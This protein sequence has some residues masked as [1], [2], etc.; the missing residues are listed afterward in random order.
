[1]DEW[2][3]KLENSLEKAY[4]RVP[5]RRLL[6]KLKRYNLHPD[7][8]DWIK[9]FLSDRIRVKLNGSLF[10]LGFRPQSYPQGSILGPLIFIIYI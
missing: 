9:A 8:I 5:H 2:T 1:L 6:H 3:E 7:L 10:E 4:D